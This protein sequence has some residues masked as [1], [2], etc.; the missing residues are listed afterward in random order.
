[1]FVGFPIIK[2]KD[3]VLAAINSLTRK[4]IGFIL[5][6]LQKKMIKGVNVKIIMSLLVKTVKNDTNEYKIMKSL[7][8]EPLD[9]LT[10]K[11]A[12]NAKKPVSSRIMDIK[13]RDRKIINNFKGL[14][15]ELFVKDWKAIWG[16]NKLNINMSIA[17]IK[18]GQ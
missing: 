17:P 10:A 14:I 8:C 3:Q 16:S 4:G 6:L 12:K 18:I 15:A 5:A 2:N 7:I 11:L 1:M 9:L 13:E